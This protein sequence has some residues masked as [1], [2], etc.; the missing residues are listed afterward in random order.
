MSV[1]LA[2]TAGFCFG[3][4][5]A[6]DMVYEEIKKGGK[7]YTYGPIIHNDEVVADLTD[8]GVGLIHTIEELK[9]ITEG[10]IIIRSHGVSKEIYDIIKNRGLKLVDATCPYVIKIH[11][12][13]KEQSELGRHIII[14]GNDKHPEVEGIEGWCMNNYTIIENTEQAENLDL[15]VN[16]KICI[17][18]QTTF[19][20]KNFQDLVEIISKKGYD[21]IVLNTICNATEERQTEARQLAKDSDAMIIIGG[22][23]SSNTRKL[24]EISK[25]ECENTYYIQTLRDLDLEELKSFRSVGITA[26]AS[27]PNNIIKEVHTACQK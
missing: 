26:G 15:S 23:H 2:K 20:Y 10:T 1:E 6:V 21:I 4:K 25:L 13:V 27:T 18:S 8:K 22:L 14:I 5:R 7:V 11:K 16:Q 3:V 9:T 24:Y 19:N 12:I 17:V